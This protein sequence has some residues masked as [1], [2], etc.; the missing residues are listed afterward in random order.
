MDSLVDDV[1]GVVGVTDSV[2]ASKQHLER[3]V[4]NQFTQFRESLPRTL[5]QEPHCYVERRAY[6]N[7]AAA[8]A[9]NT[10]S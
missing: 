9:L 5:V 8:A 6:I 7:T 2:G 10:N 3:N 1:V 4:W